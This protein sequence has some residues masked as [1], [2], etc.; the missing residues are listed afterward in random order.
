[1]TISFDG[2]P[3]GT[4]TAGPTGAFSTTITVPAGAKAGKHSITS[5]GTGCV[6]AAN[7]TVPGSGVAFTGSN[8]LGLSEAGAGL[9]LL[10]AVLVFVTRR[11]R[12]L[13]H[14]S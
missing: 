6:L 14:R 7:F 5:S 3:V 10:G 4:T 12:E 9:A 1:V 11:R 2:Q 8:V 13:S